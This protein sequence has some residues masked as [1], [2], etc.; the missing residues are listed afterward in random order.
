MH[1]VSASGGGGTGT[2]AAPA[3]PLITL[4]RSACRGQ[5]AEYRLAFYE[6]GLVVYDGLA[7]VSKA[8]RW[9][10]HVSPETVGRLVAEF[11]RIRYDTLASKYPA[12]I[13]ESPVATLGLRAGSKLKTVTHQQSSPFPPPGLSVLEDRI[14]ASVQSV[15][16]VR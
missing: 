13:G 6:D 2:A 9:Q 12:G 1:H 4:E 5:C 7:N 15:N 11:R 10:A 3:L 14:D 8:G 16:W